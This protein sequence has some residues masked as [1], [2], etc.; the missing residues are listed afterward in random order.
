MSTTMPHTEGLERGWILR[1]TLAMT[2]RNLLRYVRV[3][4]LVVFS[5]VTPVMF[6][7]LFTYVFG[8]AIET[9]SVRYI[10][11][12]LPG[13]LVQTV[14]FGST[15]SGVA[16]A[17]DRSQGKIDRFRSLPMARSAL[18]AGRTLSDL[19]RNA[20]VVL[21]LA[22]VGAVIG[23]RYH[24]G[25]PAFL[26]ALSLVVLF[27]LA[28]SWVSATL[29]FSIGNVESAHDAGFVWLFPVTF[30]S[31]AFVP[32]ETM[33]GWLQAF[34]KLNPVTSVVDAVRALALGGPTAAV[35]GRAIGWVVVLLVIFVPF[36]VHRYRK[37]N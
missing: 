13:I 27:G 29:G 3:P 1:D 37:V 28:F 14:A 5:T 32:I 10:D 18:L 30:A 8:G 24:A 9:G 35:L 23:F 34:A 12:L 11:F 36:A 17:E 19:S 25:L 7:L 16:L 20:F 21:M 4:S 2:R 26:A 33:P 22:A 6:V 31:S 15:Q